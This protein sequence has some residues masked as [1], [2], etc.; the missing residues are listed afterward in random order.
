MISCASARYC[1]VENLVNKNLMEDSEYSV[2]SEWFN[3]LVTCPQLNF[4]VDQVPILPI[5][6]HNLQ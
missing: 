3:Y 4:K 6:K 1:F 2:I 5:F